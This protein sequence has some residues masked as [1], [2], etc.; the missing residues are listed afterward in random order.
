MLDSMYS[1]HRQPFE[2]LETTRTPSFTGGPP[3]FLHYP[4]QR[5]AQ[6]LEEGK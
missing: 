4:A 6:D 1:D 3:L 5:L 2:R